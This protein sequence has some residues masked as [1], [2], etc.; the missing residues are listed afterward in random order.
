MADLSREEIKDLADQ[1][2]LSGNAF[3]MDPVDGDDVSNAHFHWR[4]ANALRQL[5][6]AT[7][8]KP[9]D[10]A[11]EFKKPTEKYPDV[12]LWIRG[13]PYIGSWYDDMHAKN[14]RP[15]WIVYGSLGKTWCRA[16]QPTHFMPL[17]KGP[18]DA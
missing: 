3:D 4:T 6:T 12:L 18:S 11:D 1:H 8:W 13:G 9:I 15:F 5:L 17:P 14:P 2:E 16:N 10:L 7:E